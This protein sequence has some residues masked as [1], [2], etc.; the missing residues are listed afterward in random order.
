MSVIASDVCFFRRWSSSSMAMA[1]R[2]ARLCNSAT[3]DSDKINS[4]NDTTANHNNNTNKCS[5]CG[6]NICNNEAH[7]ESIQESIRDDNKSNNSEA[8]S[9]VPAMNQHTLEIS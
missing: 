1:G 2:A 5:A 7:E 3:T 9:T 4:S 6:N 8:T